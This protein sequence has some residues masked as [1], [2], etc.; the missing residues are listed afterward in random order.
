MTNEDDHMT[1]MRMISN[2]WH[3][4]CLSVSIINCS[5]SVLRVSGMA[6]GTSQYGSPKP[7]TAWWAAS[8]ARRETFQRQHCFESLRGRKCCNKKYEGNG[9]WWFSEKAKHMFIQYICKQKKTIPHHLR[10]QHIRD[11]SI[12]SFNDGKGNNNRICQ[13]TQRGGHS[14]ATMQAGFELQKNG[15]IP[16]LKLGFLVRMLVDVGIPSPRYCPN[17]SKYLT[18]RRFTEMRIIDSDMSYRHI[19][20]PSQKKFRQIL[21]NSC[22]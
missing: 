2:Y 9:K 14:P 7:E 16:G 8:A 20:N 10:N 1:N 3:P 15:W 4:H 13:G 21:K 6:V 12:V 22:V 17:Q 18:H 5:S 11:T 19:K